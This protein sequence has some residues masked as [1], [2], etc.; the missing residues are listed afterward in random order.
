MDSDKEN[1]APEPLIL[2]V[3]LFNIIL[4]FLTHFFNLIS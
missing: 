3:S 1:D 4:I 2:N